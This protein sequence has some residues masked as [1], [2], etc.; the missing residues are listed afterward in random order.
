MPDSEIA[1]SI[2][3]TSLTTGESEEDLLSPKVSIEFN[4]TKE[5][6]VISNNIIVLILSLALKFILFLGNSYFRY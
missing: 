1:S 6:S 5:V 2:V 3:A 4:N